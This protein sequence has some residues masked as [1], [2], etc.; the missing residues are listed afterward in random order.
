MPTQLTPDTLRDWMRTA[1]SLPAYSRVGGPCFVLPDDTAAAQVLAELAS[2]GVTDVEGLA[3]LAAKH[4]DAVHAES[5]DRHALS[6]GK[7]EPT[8]EREHHMA[9]M[10]VHGHAPGSRLGTPPKLASGALHTGNLHADLMGGG[11]PPD[12]HEEWHRKHGWGWQAKHQ[13]YWFPIGLVRTYVQR[14]AAYRAP[15]VAT[16]S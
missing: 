3:A 16:D 10:P 14:E 4:G 13:H 5:R 15:S 8:T 1:Y 11:A 2:V 6:T 9:A 7:R 12:H